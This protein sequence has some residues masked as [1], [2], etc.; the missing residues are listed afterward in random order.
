MADLPVITLGPD[1]VKVTV[2]ACGTCGAVT[3]IEIGTFTADT[4]ELHK[5]W[6]ITQLMRL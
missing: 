4:T 1:P 6:H 2:S 3:R 5:N